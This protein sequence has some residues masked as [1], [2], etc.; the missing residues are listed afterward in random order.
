MPLFQ[1]R[2]DAGRQL[3]PLVAQYTN[4]PDAIVLALPRGGVPVGYE[5][6]TRLG[7]PLD[8]LVVRKLGVPDQPELAMGAIA[9][10]GSRVIDRRMIELLD[11]SREAFAAVEARERLELERQERE[12]RPPRPPLDLANKRVLLVDDGLATG[13]TMAAAIDAVRTQHPERI[14]AAVPVAPPDVCDL[15][16]S[17]ADEII[18]LSTPPRM[19][20]VGA[21]YVDFSQVTDDEV[22]ALLESSAAPP[23]RPSIAGTHDTVSHR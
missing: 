3:A 16:A 11:I 20:S 10:G 4:D 12:L 14:V 21:W 8:L 9:S 6:A 1:D 2:R 13:A 5:L 18:C 22:R 15:L 19:R 17:R 23:D 7:L